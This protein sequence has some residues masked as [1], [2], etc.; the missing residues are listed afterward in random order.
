M[1]GVAQ[2]QLASPHGTQQS[3]RHVEELIT[4]LHFLSNLLLPSNV[5]CSEFQI[6]T[7]RRE[8]FLA[9]A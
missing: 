1:Q 8:L 3:K 9:T 6:L 2:N 4:D 5:S 7:R